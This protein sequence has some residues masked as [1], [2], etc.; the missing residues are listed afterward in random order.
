MKIQNLSSHLA[1]YTCNVYLV[2]GKWNTIRDINTLIDVGRDDSVIEKILDASTGVGKKRVEQVV[3]THSHFD[4]ASLLPAIRTRFSPK[5]CAASPFL[6]GVDVV[7]RDGEHLKIGDRDFQVIAITEDSSD[8][9]CL[10][11]ED[12]GVLFAGDTSLVIWTTDG[13]YEPGFVDFLETLCL[14]DVRAMYFGHG[15]PVL[16]GCPDILRASLENVRKSLLRN[17]PGPGQLPD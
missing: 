5:V 14:K 15:E 16:S 3:L 2:T 9:I 13:T 17:R 6:E 4:H 12:E 10:F 8:S 1:D 11:C 7:L